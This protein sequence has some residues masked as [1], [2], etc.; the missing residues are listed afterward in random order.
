[1]RTTINTYNVLQHSNEIGSM[2]SQI[3]LVLEMNGNWNLFLGKIGIVRKR[4]DISIDLLWTNP[5][6]SSH[7]LYIGTIHSQVPSVDAVWFQ[8]G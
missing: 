4:N 6:M 2:S 7:H 5:S 1:M 8:K 3:A